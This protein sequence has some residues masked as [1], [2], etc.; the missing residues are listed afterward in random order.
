MAEAFMPNDQ[1]TQTVFGFSIPTEGGVPLAS[2]IK[3][4]LKVLDAFLVAIEQTAWQVRAFGE[5]AMGA[6]QEVQRGVGRVAQSSRE[7][8]SELAGWP[9]RMARLTSTGLALG[10]IAASYRLHQTKAAFVSRKRAA[11]SLVELHERSAERLY[12]L[13]VRHGGAFLKVG[14]ML[15]ARPDLLPEPYVRE[16][17]KLQDAA[18]AVPFALIQAAVEAELGRPLAELFATFDE[19]PLASASIGQVHRATLADGTPVAVKVQRPGIADLVEMDLDL[20]EIFIRALGDSLP[21]VDI[22][23]ILRES[24]A[25]VSAEVDYLRE[26]ALTARV[27]AFFEGDTAIAAPRVVSE[28]STVRVLTTRFEEGEKITT[29]LDRL[30]TRAAEGDPGAQERITRI[31]VRVLTAY[32]R[33]TLTLGVFQADPHPGNLLVD[34]NDRVVVLDFGCAK[35]VSRESRR[36]LIELGRGFIGENPD[37]MARAMEALGF[38]TQ[39]GDLAGLKAYA[40]IVL[41]EVNAMRERGG[42]WPTQAEMLGQMAVMLRCIESDPITNLP[43]EFVMLGRVFGVLSG[44]FLHYRPDIDAAARVLPLILFAASSLGAFDGPDAQPSP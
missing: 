12:A 26:A 27:S 14:Q 25:M 30:L 18:P 35:E 21:P 1:D 20:L 36:Q 34:D 16:L 24:R 32:I 11:R 10:G 41:R 7:T 9:S 39:R 17:S 33:Q 28:L 29:L 5:S 8:A 40:E 44:L 2:Q 19:V 13:S 22:D 23:T 4:W 42:D 37:G 15:S 3:L 38:R 31:L 43:E 6:A